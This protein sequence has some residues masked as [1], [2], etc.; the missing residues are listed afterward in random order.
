[1]FNNKCENQINKNK[2]NKNKT[3]TKTLTQKSTDHTQTIKTKQ[4]QQINKTLKT[5]S[6]T[7]T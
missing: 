3:T 1:M 7:R 6:K 4:R 2:I 5:Q